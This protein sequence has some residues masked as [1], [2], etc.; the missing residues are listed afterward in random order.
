LAGVGIGGV[1]LNRDRLSADAFNPE[2][3]IYVLCSA[4]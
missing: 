1:R 3:K 2:Y 4:D